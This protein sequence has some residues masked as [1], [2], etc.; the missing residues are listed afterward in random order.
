MD[1]GLIR[2]NMVFLVIINLRP[3]F[4][5]TSMGAGEGLELKS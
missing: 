2:F 3:Y 4:A 1:S 5:V